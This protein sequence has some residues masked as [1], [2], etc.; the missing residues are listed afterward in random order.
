[1]D[2]VY[3]TKGDSASG[4]M[5][6]CSDYLETS[7]FAVYNKFYSDSS[8]CTDVTGTAVVKSRE[9]NTLGLYDM[10]GNVVKW[11]FD[12]CSLQSN[13]RLMSRGSFDDDAAY[14]Q[15]GWRGWASPWAAYSYF[16]FRV[17]K[18]Y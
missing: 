10:S 12:W 13:C 1:M 14:T 5:V 4:A 3:Y 16:S 18:T 6:S 15:V 9:P 11:M 2:G 8:T 7:K 17:V